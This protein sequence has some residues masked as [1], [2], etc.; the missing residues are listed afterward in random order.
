MVSSSFAFIPNILTIMAAKSNQQN[1]GTIKSSN[2][3]TEIIEYSAPDETAVCNLASIALPTFVENTASG[4]VYN[5]QKLHDVAK[6]VAPNLN[7]IIRCQLL[8]HR[9]SSS[10]KHAPSHWCWCA[11]FC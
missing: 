7:R 4:N 10:F 11:G 3:C 5:F 2:L 9:R 6:A 1:L 8:P